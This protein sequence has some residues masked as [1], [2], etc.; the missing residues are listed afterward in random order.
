M[1]LNKY[2]D[3]TLKQDA[4]Q[5]QIDR[6][7]SRSKVSMRLLLLLVLLTEQDKNRTL[8]AQMCLYSSRFPLGVN[9]LG[10]ESF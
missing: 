9:N 10:R 3:H 4:S 7:P 1:K 5:E 8:R 2:I 6:L